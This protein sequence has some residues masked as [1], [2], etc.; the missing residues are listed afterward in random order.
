M[1]SWGAEDWEQRA[2]KRAR[3]H[4]GQD[5][6]GGIQQ[7]WRTSNSGILQNI[8]F[9]PVGLQKSDRIKQVPRKATLNAGTGLRG[10]VSLRSLGLL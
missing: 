4:P 10:F 1:L 9:D 7:G 8:L 2:A 3:S 6:T 5:Q